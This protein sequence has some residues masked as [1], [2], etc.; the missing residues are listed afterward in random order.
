MSASAELQE[1]ASGQGS[2]PLGEEVA[3]LAAD[4]PAAEQVG[5]TESRYDGPCI[6]RNLRH[7][8]S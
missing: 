7:L 1:A 8:D 3:D 5:E 4:S 2:D 6:R